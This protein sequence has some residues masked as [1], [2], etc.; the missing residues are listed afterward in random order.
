[1]ISSEALFHISVIYSA[2]LS[3]DPSQPA[4]LE[5]ASLIGPTAIR[6]DIVIGVVA[7]GRVVIEQSPAALMCRPRPAVH[8]LNRQRVAALGFFKGR[9]VPCPGVWAGMDGQPDY[10]GF[11]M[12]Q[13]QAVSR[14]LRRGFKS[15]AY[16]T[17]SAILVA[18]LAC[19][20]GAAFALQ[21]AALRLLLTA[22]NRE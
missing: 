12:I 21:K 9:P 10:S 6:W 14:Y 1:M 20:L 8:A 17:D 15:M 5:P 22:M 3:V 18:T 2:G 13:N 16:V 7:T 11:P 19:S 4:T